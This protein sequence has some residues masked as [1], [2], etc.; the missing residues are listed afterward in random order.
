VNGVNEF[1]D[2]LEALVHGG[3]TQ[4]RYFIDPAQF[5]KHFGADSSGENFA[6]ARFELVHDV[7]NYLFQRHETG[8]ALFKSFRNAGGKFAPIK[9][10]MRSVAFHDTQVRALDFFVGRKAIFAF[11]T[12]AATPDTGTIPRLAGI[13]DFVI[14]RP[15]LGATHSVKTFITTP[16]IVAS[17]HVSPPSSEMILQIILVGVNP[18]SDN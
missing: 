11:K 5:L 9:R 17:I 1:I 15:A 18:R 6:S 13:D 4:I 14:T 7:V 8:R 10:L 16:H 12:F 2:I 3:V